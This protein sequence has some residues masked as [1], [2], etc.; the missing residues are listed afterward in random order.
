METPTPADGQNLTPEQVDALDFLQKGL[1]SQVAAVVADHGQTVST[2][3]LIRYGGKCFVA[4]V[5]H[6][7]EGVADLRTLNFLCAGRTFARGREGLAWCTRPGDQHTRYPNG[8]PKPD[9]GLI[10]LQ[11]R[12][13]GKLDAVN[14]VTPDRI[15]FDGAAP[16][17]EVAFV[18]FPNGR[19]IDY[20]DPPRLTKLKPDLFCTELRGER[21]TQAEQINLDESIDVLAAIPDARSEPNGR[22]AEVIEDIR[23]ISG[24]GVFLLP[25]PEDR[26]DWRPENAQLIGIQRGVITESKRFVFHKAPMLDIVLQHYTENPPTM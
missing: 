20:G 8:I 13:A 11:Q 14:W 3:V 23:G 10:E 19:I 7:L 18:G 9:I 16:G 22:A 5:L 15:S 21:P 6:A 25:R 4:T 26:T 24:A 17:R 12:F 1:I 2:G